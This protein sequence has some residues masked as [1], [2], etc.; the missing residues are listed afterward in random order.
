MSNAKKQSGN[1][2]FKQTLQPL[3]WFLVMASVLACA[4]SFALDMVS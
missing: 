2:V 3:L 4:S 1:S